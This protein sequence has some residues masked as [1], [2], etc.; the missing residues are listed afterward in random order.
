MHHSENEMEIKH[1]LL[2]HSTARSW[3]IKSGFI[4][5][6][7]GSII[8]VI[9][10]I[11]L[12]DNCVVLVKNVLTWV[13]SFHKC[14]PSLFTHFQHINHG[15]WEIHHW[16]KRK[17]KKKTM[18]LIR[19]TISPLDMSGMIIFCIR[20]SW[21]R[22]WYNCTKTTNGTTSLLKLREKLKLASLEKLAT[23]FSTW[24]NFFSFLFV[25][26]ETKTGQFKLPF[27]IPIFRAIFLHFIR[28]PVPYHIIIRK[29]KKKRPPV[30]VTAFAKDGFGPLSTIAYKLQN[31][32]AMGKRIWNRNQN[33]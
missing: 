21:E 7:Q 12:F 28:L 5:T 18:K 8:R 10:N 11:W 29:D 2:Q 13:S 23:T 19:S 32:E 4:S 1:A 22:Q 31:G 16:Y 26:S 17:I 30:T 6:A 33:L 9:N 24:F 14:D 25:S 27:A 3:Q 15:K 20:N